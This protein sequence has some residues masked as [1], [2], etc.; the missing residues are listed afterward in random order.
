MT[1]RCSFCDKVFPWVVGDK[2][3]PID[4]L[5]KHVKNHHFEEYVRA[6]HRRRRL[7]G[8]ADGLEKYD[9]VKSDQTQMKFDF[10]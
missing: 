9:F 7:V 8:E 4:R 2:K 10:S 1:I 5:E 3:D 6:R